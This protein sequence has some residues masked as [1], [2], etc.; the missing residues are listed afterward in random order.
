MA[1][2][3]PR[4]VPRNNC[5]CRPLGDRSRPYCELRPGR[6]V[7]YDNRSYCPDLRGTVPIMALLLDSG[8]IAKLDEVIGFDRLGYDG[9]QIALRKQATRLNQLRRTRISMDFRPRL[10]ASP[11]ASCSATSLRWSRSISIRCGPSSPGTSPYGRGPTTFWKLTFA[12]WDPRHCAMACPGSRL[13][14]PCN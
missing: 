2:S 5:C 10:T 1:C 9:G 11:P 4:S 13:V 14:N 8:I 12:S 6:Q 7:E 3:F